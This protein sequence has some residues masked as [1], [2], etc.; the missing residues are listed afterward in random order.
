M[1]T[2]KKQKKQLA[3]NNRLEVMLVLFLI[4]TVAFTMFIKS[5][6]LIPY[7][8]PS[9]SMENTLNIGDRFFS[10]GPLLDAML[11]GPTVEHGDIITFKDDLKWLPDR[12]KTQ[13]LVKR[14][15]GLGGDVIQGDEKGVI[16]RNGEVIEEPYLKTQ[17]QTR[18]VPFNIVVPEGRIFVMGDNR[19]ESADSRYFI[20]SEYHG[21]ISMDSVTGRAIFRIFPFDSIGS[22]R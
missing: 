1:K 21:T 14:V 18:P 10:T 22:L 9:Q 8:V 12:N 13:Y 5:F 19:D 7:V 17:D 6:V 3:V 20:D 4:L 16:M 2:S 15:I 11:P